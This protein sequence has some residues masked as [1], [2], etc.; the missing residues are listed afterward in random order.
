MK[1]SSLVLNINNIYSKL[2]RK[3]FSR[4]KPRAIDNK[5]QKGFFQKERPGTPDG[6]KEELI[7]PTEQDSP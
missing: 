3:Y 6:L 1:G 5:V 7:L 2:I 4:V